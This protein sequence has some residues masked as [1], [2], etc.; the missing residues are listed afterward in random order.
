MRVT[1]NTTSEAAASIACVGSGDENSPDS[2]GTAADFARMATLQWK[3]PS[4]FSPTNDPVPAR[5]FPDSIQGIFN[6]ITRGGIFMWPLLICSIVAVTVIMLR[7]MALR[8]KNVV[9]LVLETEIERLVPGASPER[10]V[11]IAQ[12]DNSPL[13]RICSSRCNICAGRGTKMSRRCKPRAP[14]NGPARARPDRARSDHRHRAAA[15]FARDGF[16]LVHVLRTSA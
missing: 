7:G 6:F 5:R 13:A 16:R 3:K 2:R 1:E 10:L 15:R 12:V 14:R 4:R 11:R 8:E 9:P